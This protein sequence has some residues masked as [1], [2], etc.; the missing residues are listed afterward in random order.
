[1]LLKALFEDETNFLGGFFSANIAVDTPNY[2]RV[3][4][5][6]LVEEFRLRLELE[7]AHLGTEFVQEVVRH[8][9]DK[10][11]RNSNEVRRLAYSHH[12]CDAEACEAV[13]LVPTGLTH[14]VNWD[15]QSTGENRDFIRISGEALTEDK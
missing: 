2:H 8:Q 6:K 1:M 13:R 9:D 3:S 14:Q 11:D 12:P 5:D 4:G 15:A 10:N 7:V